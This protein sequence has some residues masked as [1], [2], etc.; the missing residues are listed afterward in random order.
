[1][2]NNS[3]NQKPK[4]QRGPRSRVRGQSRSGPV[5]FPSGAVLVGG[6]YIPPPKKA[7]RGPRR[8]LVQAPKSSERGSPRKKR[9]P[10]PQTDT[11]WRKYF[12]KFWGDRG[13]PWPYIDPVLQWSAWGT[14]PGAYRTRWGP[15][16]PRHKSRNL[17]RVIDT[18]TCGVADLAG[19]VPVLGAPAGALCR[20]AAHLVRF[21][22]DGANFITGNIPGMG[23]SIFLLALLSALSFGEAS[24][25]RNGGHVVSND[26][27]SSQILWAASDWAIHEVGCVPCVDS[28]CWVPLTSS[29]SVRDESVIV[30][31]LG[32]H[33]DVLAALASVCST[34][35]I[36]E[37]CGTATLTYITFLSKFFMSLNLTADCECFLYPGAISTF[38][39]TL[40]ALQSMM[41]N[42]SGFVSMFSGVPNTLFTIFT[43][44][45]WGV[46]LALCLYGTTNN[47]FKLCLLLLAYSGLVSCDSDY[48]NVSLSCNFTVK[49]MWGWT[50]F[51]KWALLNGQ[52]LNCT[53]GSPYNPKCKGPLDFNIT[54]DPVVAY[55]RTRSHP[56]CPYHVSR[57]CSVLNASRVCG[58]PTCFGPAPIEVGVTDRDGNLASWNDTGQFYFDLRSPHR[59][60]RG[61][62]YGCVWLNSTGWVKQC[63]APPCIM[64]LMSNR[65]RQFVC[66]SDCFRQNP[67]A[68]YQLC[69]Q[70]PWISYN[71]LIDY[72]D[73]YLHFPCTENFT[74]YPVRMILGDGARDVRVACKFNRSASCR[75]EDRLRA[76]IVSLLYSVTTAAV[77]PC[78]FSPLPAFTTGLIHL[79]RNL[80]DVQYVWAMTP[81]AVNLFLRLEWAVFFLLLLMDAKVCAI[82]WFCLCLALQ[83][84]A[85]LS[86]TMRLIALSYI[87][88][89]SLLYALLFYCIIYFTPS[90]VPPFCVFVYY[91]KFSLAFM[92]LAL[93]HRAWAFDNTSAVTAAF[94]IA[95]FCLYITC[96]S[97]YKK[98]FLLVKWWLE[99]WDVR[100]ECAWRYLGPRVNPKDEKLAFALCFS[101]FYPSLFRAVYLPLAV[102]CGSFSM[103]N[104]RV[105]K[106][107]YLRRAE[108]L[109]RVLTICRDVYGSKWVQWCILWVASHFGTFLYD[110]LTPIDTWAAPGLRDLMHSLEPVTLSPMERK[111]V[112]WGARKVAC[113]DILHGLPVSARL[114]REICLGPA[115]RLT[116][117][118]WR[119]LSPITATVTKTRG[120]PSAIVCCLT[121][122]DKYPHRGHCYILTSLTKTFMGTVCK[123]VLWS[124]HHGGGTA[125]LASDKS[126]LLQ[127]LCSPGDDLVAWPA[128][129]GS[130]SFQPCTCGSADVFLVTRTGQVVPA[131]KTSEKDASLISPLPISSLKGSSGGPVLCKDGDLVGIFC[132]ASVTRG[133]AKRIHFADMRTRSV[134]SCPPKYTDL[135]SPPAVPSSYQ[136]SFLHAP[137]G[138]GKSTKMPLSYVELGYH[139]LVL[140]P[141]V[142]ST[143]S[144]G[145]YMDKTYGECPN[146]RTGASCKTTGSKLT[147]STYGK[148]L[149]DGG[150]S[151]GAYDII[152]CDECHST[153][154]TSV[155]GIGSVLDGAESKGVKLVVLA[156]A[157]PPGSQT[158]PHPNIDEEALTQ[159]GDIPFYG[160]MLKSS[161]LLSGRH[162]IFCHSKKKCEEVALLLRKAGANA[163]TYYRGLDVSV[164]PNEGNVVVVATDALMTGY[165]GNFDTVT[166]CNTAVELD[167]EFSLDPT[168]TMVTTPKPSDAVCRTQRRGRTGRG[169]RGTYYYVNSGE[170]PS[171]VL[172]SSVLCEC[173]DSGLAWFGLSPAQVTVL[174]QAY[175]KQPGLPTGLDHTEFWESV[176]IGLP[177][178]D[179]FFLS[180]LKQQGVTFPYLTAIQATV[181]LN[182]QAKAP[183]K[184]ERWKVL[185]R[186]ITT[187]RTPTPLLYRLEDTHDDLTFTH[188]VTKYI[189]ACMEA[190]IDTQ[191]NAWVIAGGCVA[192]LVA[193]AALT[194]SVAI[195]AEVHVNEKVVVVPHKGV[196]YAD[197]DELEE[198]FD[199][200]QYI[201]QGYEWASRAAQK[202]R[203]V[204]TSIEPPT[205][206]AQP[207]LS[208]IEKFWNQHMWNI[209]S[210]VQYLAGLTTLPY[211]PSVACLMG[212][213]SGLTTGLPRP[214]MAFLTILGG[215]AASMVA[216]PQAASTFVGAGLA[217]IAIGAVGFTDVIVGLLAGYG[218]GVAGALT[219]FKILSGVTPSGE[220]LIN[221]LP[222]LLNPG[223]LA[224]GVGAAFILK[225]YTGGSEG[226]VAWVNRLI[227][228]CSRGNH[229]S[230]DH[231]VQQQQVVRDVIACL[232]SLTLTRLVKTIHN[233]VTSENDQNCDFT[234]IYF[235]IQWLMKTLYD[236]FT[237]AKGI[238]LPHLPGFPIISCDTGYSGRW[239]GDGLVTTRCGCG[240]MITGNVRNERIRITGS[241]KCRNVWLNAFP[242]NS[243]T[244][245]GPRPNPYD[246]WKTA[247]LRIT[248]TE[249]VEFE[250]RGTAVR[251]TGATADKLRIPCQVPEPDLMTYIDGVRIHRLAPTPKPML[252]DEVV[253]LIG[254]HTYPVG[255][256]LP[257][258]PEPDVDTVSSLLTDPGHVTAETAARRL[259]RGRTVD[260]ESSSG[261]ELSAVSRGAASRVSEEHE[262]QG[263][264]VRP[265]TGEDELAWIRSFYGRSVTIEVDDKVINFDSWTINSGSEGEHSR[266]SV[267]APD[268]D[269]VVVA[270]PP[271]PP[272]PAW[273]R[274]DYVPALVSGCPIKPG[275]ATPE[276]SEPS[277][278][279]SAPV[280][281]KEEPT[282]DEGGNETDPDMPP[283]EGEEPA[284]EDDD[285]EWETTSEKAESCSLS[286]SWTGALVTAT[287]REE[288][289]HP[290]GPLSNTL[291]TKHNLVYQTTTASAS[292]R[293]AKVTIDRE[294]ILDKHYFDTV[295]AVKKKASEVTADLL[296]WDEVARLTPKNTA[297]SKSGLSG[298][299]V[300]QLTR[301]ARRELNS[302]WQNLLSDSEEPIPTTV[303]AKNEVFV[304]SP[305]ARKPARLI[306]YPDLPV[307][308][309][310][311]RAMYD[312]FQ[313]L[314]YAV[315]GKAY[316]FQYTPRQ[317][318][319]RLLDMWRHFKNPM[320]FSY[321]T[322]CFDSTVTPHDIDT[323]RDIF[324][325]AALPDEAKTVIKNLTS[326]LYR[327]SPMYN[328]R[329]DLVG[330]RECRA[331][332]VFPTSMGNTLTNFI[333]ATA[334]A[335]AA[336]LSDPQ[337]LICGDDLVCITSSK[338]V[339]EDEQA[340]RDF[341][342]A[343]AKYSAIPGDHPK[344]YYDLEQIT[345]C[346]SNVTVAQDRNGRPYYFLT[347]DPT[348]PLAR[349]SW[350]TISHSP[351]NS[352]LGNIIAFAPTVWVR[353]VFLTHFFGLLLQQ[354]A[355]D[356]NY[357]FEMYG[358][359]YSVNPLDLPAIIYKLHGPEAF[360]LTNYSPY[361]VQRVA[362]ALQKLGS[363]P[364]RAWK[365]RA[366]LVRSKLKVRGGRYSVVADYLFGF[367][368]AYRPKRPAPPGVNSIDVS[369][370]FSIGDDSIGD[371]YRQL[372]N[373]AGRWIPLLLLLPLLAAILYF[374][375]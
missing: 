343:M 7:I 319:D 155:L 172:S 231:Y 51:P 154:S 245:G 297:R 292:A 84:E 258:T 315:M 185:S 91:W 133:V 69:G 39:F 2:G 364:L 182:A 184:D 256:T 141:S 248:S 354:D 229:V 369:G 138:S 59:P 166:D 211:N 263:G 225:R 186:Y 20:G 153:D 356:R 74:V 100:I 346:S 87:A 167:I 56:P 370:W 70:G 311:K 284:E 291:I 99:Y 72:T 196:L 194:G 288:R 142:A 281:E 143:L 28:S 22:E 49:Q 215:W 137:T 29:I 317:R 253:V 234:A 341:T 375:K 224:V 251:V 9:Q 339:E 160:K 294:Q 31:G 158:V 68:T 114:G 67:K 275:S 347:R 232:E 169:R 262:M 320:G 77:P 94:S 18:L 192:A 348:T 360:D 285:G 54:T 310:E 157:T 329:G 198:C 98:L 316:G 277:A 53:E 175:L 188:P 344:P 286:Y 259:R 27:N 45:H 81:S 76:S 44:G 355:V 102:V 161:L 340:L 21:V 80:S 366:K 221:L 135:D 219:A 302:M 307:R 337:F 333:K 115:D 308:A 351:V 151:A 101:F 239:A 290:I 104:K 63:G 353:L 279:E 372:P 233:F 373:V 183:S 128:P 150:V 181:C 55:S 345:S 119:L 254:N 260:V 129:A 265:L 210:G 13:Y 273:M 299:D 176:F 199:H 328:S 204:A 147:Y 214:A 190:E 202:I 189:Q 338:G 314:P 145:P 293:M 359:T 287:R 78:H 37:A 213:V 362:A 112:K 62:W 17:G 124:V 34:L 280:E 236:C 250:R 23:F 305:T 26:C 12:P 83:A 324:L 3:K 272:G 332:G 95:L 10:P 209:L 327:G 46:I 173:Y 93:P 140:N 50:F 15:R 304:S 86:D 322:K 218:A 33:I 208:A 244:T 303:M 149:A 110:H 313:K 92:V 237:W 25:V 152:I 5:V 125:T 312:L 14:S 136:V 235:F 242:I 261:S 295:T 108:V 106:V 217:G 130:K 298:S 174:L 47:Y 96:L 163:V 35:G 336:G 335:R 19:Y 193:V 75:T 318:V 374:N 238:I 306:V 206:Q 164:I 257:C 24:V 358:S 107:A 117:K 58:K 6:R 103:I 178:V 171:G 90:R 207:M 278:T 342:S 127:V 349:A 132:S 195:I 148:F 8:G 197:F 289:R 43:N 156:T 268:N 264:P 331:S 89:D 30:R 350:E 159:S 228:F 246:T 276:P 323:E 88:D 252:R 212:F 200:H 300:R 363:P 131:R 41:P 222:S 65:S 123:G 271:P 85:Y 274:K 146:I 241:R 120:I 240:N 139:V 48:I 243:T 216:P 191:T 82:L 309:C 325:S 40:R 126:S 113:G 249:Y 57:P 321:D 326:R 267:V 11:S 266:E 4:P 177:T 367:A 32:S 247:V 361:E 180:Q 301:A 144:F 38:E 269:Q 201:Q 365:R 179:A 16:D 71:C 368:S 296:T 162:L 255:A 282:V 36:G 118:G 203:E 357:E 165:S 283:L 205:G 121:G 187:N 227:A 226:L 168:F 170:R 352:W 73:R 111:V 61:R 334:A 223:A 122:R 220:D 66:P 1:M 60:P 109:V 230:P 97:C 79:D 134:S 116:S 42:L 105:Q 371:I 330:K 52:R 270:E 64:N